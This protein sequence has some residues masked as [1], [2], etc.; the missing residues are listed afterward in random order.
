MLIGVFFSIQRFSLAPLVRPAVAA[1][2]SQSSETFTNNV[3]ICQWCM[4][5]KVSKMQTANS[6]HYQLK[7]VIS[8]NSCAKKLDNVMLQSR[9]LNMTS[10]K[11]REAQMKMIAHL[12]PDW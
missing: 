5:E 1:K 6:C 4:N 9:D 11:V 12:T 8:L 2:H 7:P 10:N 3:R